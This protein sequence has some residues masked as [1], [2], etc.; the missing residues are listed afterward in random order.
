M[1]TAL[2][3]LV[4]AGVDPRP[5]LARIAAGTAAML[6]AY[7]LVLVIAWL[8]ESGIERRARRR[9]RRE[10]IAAGLPLS[11]DA[12]RAAAASAHQGGP[13]AAA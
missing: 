2:L 11:L 6:A 9:Q 4:L 10:Y 8:V 12:R 7:G 1:H 5:L 13:D 3:W